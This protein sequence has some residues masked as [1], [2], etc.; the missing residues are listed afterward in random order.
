MGA[1]KRTLSLVG[2]FQFNYTAVIVRSHS[3]L[4]KNEEQARASRS[5]RGTAPFL[6]VSGLLSKLAVISSSGLGILKGLHTQ[7]T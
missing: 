4:V 3:S 2:T 7:K 5:F 6:G 1:E